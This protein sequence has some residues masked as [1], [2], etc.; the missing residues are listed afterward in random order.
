MERDL[1]EDPEPTANPQ[2]ATNPAIRQLQ[3]LGY[4]VIIAP[5]NA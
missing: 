5:A 2:K 1:D 3:S 4:S